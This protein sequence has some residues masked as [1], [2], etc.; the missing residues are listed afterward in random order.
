MH[1]TLNL[2]EARTRFNLKTMNN[3]PQ[4]SARCNPRAALAELHALFILGGISHPPSLKQDTVEQPEALP[5]NLT[6][7][8]RAID[9]VLVVHADVRIKQSSKRREPLE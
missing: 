2:L 7:I 6:C 5:H 8:A 4:P 9:S 1:A 3:D